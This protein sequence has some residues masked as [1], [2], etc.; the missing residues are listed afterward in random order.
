MNRSVFLNPLASLTVISVLSAAPTA[1]AQNCAP[2]TLVNS[3][4]MEDVQ[5]TDTVTIPATIEGRAEKLLVGIADTTQLWD[6]TA[7]TLG[8]PV[9]EGRRMMDG[10]GRFSEDVSRVQ[11]LSLGSMQTGNFFTQISPDPDFGGPGTDGVLGTD[12]MMRYDI[13]L[14]F[15]QHRLNYFSPEQCQ[16]A[17]I[18]WNP[19][20]LTAMKIAAYADVVYVPVT[21]DGHTIIAALDTTADKTFLNPDVAQKLFGLKA[22]AR[23]LLG[24]DSMEAGTVRDSGALLKTGLHRFSMLAFGGLA[25]SNPQI[26][27]PIDTLSQSTREFHAN[28][29]IADQYPLSQLLPDMVIGMDVLRQT[30]LYVSFQDQRVYVSPAGD[31]RATLPPQPIK[32]SWFNVWRYGYDTYIH[33]YRHPFFAL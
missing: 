17:G 25:F 27:I 1:M 20:K 11:D 15:A 13:D 9:Q 14:D 24:G 7:S 18:Y 19:A 4:P 26:A 16:D 29:A 3:L 2:P 23:A 33:Q 32:T 12:M 8:L 22:D 30:H 10:G 28:H 21:L 5:G 6:A 31:A